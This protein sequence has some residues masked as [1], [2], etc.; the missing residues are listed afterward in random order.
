MIS[1]LLACAEP[2]DVATL[3][4][5]APLDPLGGTAPLAD[6]SGGDCPDLGASGKVTLTS[7]GVPRVARLYVPDGGSEGRPALFVWHPLGMS[8]RTIAQYMDAEALADAWE[9]TIVVPDSRDENLFEWDFWTVNDYDATLYDDLRTCLVREAGADPTRIATT[10]MSA[11]GLWTSWLAVH[12]ADTLATAVPMSGGADPLFE[13]DTPAVPL[14]VLLMYGGAADVWG[15]EG[16]EVDFAAATLD[17]A[18]ALAADGNTVVLCD[19]GLGHTI[20]PEATDMLAAWLPAH[21][22]G[23]PSPFANSLDGLPTWCEAL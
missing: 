3:P 8:A 20:P 16:L 22:F 14:P 7:A 13:Y 6:V 15:D 18:D 5:G 23:A 4:A 12:R 17:F 9:T 2:G 10:G 11:G 21:R 1:L 19:H